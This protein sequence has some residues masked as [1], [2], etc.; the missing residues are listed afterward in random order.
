VFNGNPDHIRE[1]TTPTIFNIS[2]IQRHHRHG[3]RAPTGLKHEPSCGLTISS[4]SALDDFQILDGGRSTQVEE[5]LARA[6]IACAVTLPLS[7]MREFML[8]QDALS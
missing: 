6:T 5:I 4:L 8:D 3:P 2:D 1:P 7:E